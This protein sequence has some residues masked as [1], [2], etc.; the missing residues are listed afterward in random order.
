MDRIRISYC[1]FFIS[2]KQMSLEI[3]YRKTLGGTDPMLWSSITA[4]RTG[5]SN[6]FL[7]SHRWEKADIFF[8]QG[9]LKC[10]YCFFFRAFFFH[11]ECPGWCCAF[12]WGLGWGASALQVHTR[13]LEWDLAPLLSLL[14]LGVNL[15]GSNKF[16]SNG[17]PVL[18]VWRRKCD[19]TLRRQLT[20]LVLLVV[21]SSSSLEAS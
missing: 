13:M 7:N 11:L 1:V 4:T 3:I 2:L 8:F 21:V 9:A 15:L 10:E 16:V 12:E 19:S 14:S 6:I 17:A 18:W 20:G 5:G